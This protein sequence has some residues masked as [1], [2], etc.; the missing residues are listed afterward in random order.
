MKLFKLRR[1]FLAIFFMSFFINAA[2]AGM[3]VS[4]MRFN[5]DVKKNQK[6]VTGAIDLYADNTAGATRFK[7]YSG[8]F[9]V[10]NVGYMIFNFKPEDK[11]RTV[12]QFLINPKEV[13]I[14]PNI[15]Q[16]VRFTIPNV[17][18]LPDGESR[19]MAFIEDIKTREESLPSPSEGIKASLTIRQ[20][21]GIPIYIDKGNVIKTGQINQLV[22]N[23]KAK[24]YELEVS[25]KGN[26]TIRVTG[27][28]QL[29]N[30][31]KIIKEEEFNDV[32]VLPGHNRII[33][34]KMDLSVLEQK[35]NL[36]L[37]TKLYYK[38]AN[39]RKII[40]SKEVDLDKGNT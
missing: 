14:T 13:T 1:L 27:V 32:A 25:S 10:S 36:K 7:T 22:F 29:V 28:V 4:P 33:A 5:F 24:I 40:L 16:T 34:G 38:N 12:S 31:K 17:D 39:K 37:R 11:K 19:V 3:K 26:S 2:D 9:D 30:N 21:M 6:Y 23:K 20:R 15:K 35:D 8:Y 18:K